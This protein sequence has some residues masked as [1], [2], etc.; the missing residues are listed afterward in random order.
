MFNLNPSTLIRQFLKREINNSKKVLDVGCGLGETAFFLISSLN[1]QVIGIDLDKNKVHRAN[2]KFTKKPTKGLALCYIY[3]SIDINKKFKK[4]AFD[5]VIIIHT[6]HHLNDLSNVLL[7]IKY[8]LKNGGKIFVCEY[9]RDY[10]ELIDNCPRFSNKKIKSMLKTAGFR[11]I[12]NNNF[13]KNLIMISARK[14]KS[15]IFKSSYR[16]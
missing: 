7:K 5:I 10:G 2:E 1:C 11:N 9:Q 6:L 8:I 3:D 4:N 16:N 12:K 13:H 14:G 15:K